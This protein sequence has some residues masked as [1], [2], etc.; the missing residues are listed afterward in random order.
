[1]KCANCD[2]DAAFT[3]THTAARAVN[4]CEKCLPAHLRVDA[5]SGKY[6]LAVPAVKRSKKKAADENLP[7]ASEASASDSE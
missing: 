4:Y 6:P 7:R 3:V 1:M 2:K 5:Y